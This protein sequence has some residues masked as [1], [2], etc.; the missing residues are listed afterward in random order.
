MSQDE[1][2][3][4]FK[5]MQRLEA[6]FDETKA[7]LK[8]DVNRVYDLVDEDLKRQETSEQERL[9]MSSQLDRHQG[10]ITQLAV[11]TK[12]KLAPET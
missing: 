1:F 9:A 2:T 8:A 12:T 11:G 7:E 4:L 3:K 6:K 5:Y 10:W